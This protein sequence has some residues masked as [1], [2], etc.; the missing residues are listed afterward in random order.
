VKSWEVKFDFIMR[1][2]HW[3]NKL[4]E[5]CEEELRY[6]SG[7]LIHPDGLEIKPKTARTLKKTLKA[8]F[9][10]ESDPRWTPSFTNSIYGSGRTVDRDVRSRRFLEMLK[11]VDGVFAQRFCAFPHEEWT[12]EKYDLFNLKLIWELISDEFLD[13]QLTDKG[14]LLTTRFAE[15]KSARGEFKLYSS[16][17][18]LSEIGQTDLFNKKARWLRF[19][20]PLYKEYSRAT[21]PMNQTYLHGVLC[22]TRGAGKPPNLAKLQSKIKF[23]ETVTTPDNTGNTQVR[24]VTQAMWEEITL[25]PDHI[26]TGLATKA[27]VT[28]NTSATIEYTQLQHGTVQAIQDICKGRAYGIRAMDIDLETGSI[29]G[30]LKKDISEGT[31]VF[32]RCLEEVLRM[33]PEERSRAT[34][35][36]VDE[37]G[38]NRAVTKGVACLKVVLD[39]VN[40]ICAIPL[41]KGFA[42]SHSGMKKANHMWNVFKEYEVNPLNKLLFNPEKVEETEFSDHKIRDTEFKAVFAVSTDYETATDYLSH[43]IGKAIAYPWMLKCG[44]PRV[45][46]NLVCEVAFRPRTILYYGDPVVGELTGKEPNQRSVQSSRGVLMGDPLT[47]VVLHFTNIVS[48]RLSW[49]ILEE[50]FHNKVFKEGD[51]PFEHLRALLQTQGVTTN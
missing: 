44:I 2:T 31:Y 10:G 43:K 48:R 28:V 7:E 9:R 47:K 45:L 42:S 46:R 34:V 20:L 21:A 5:L 50:D 4:Q 35:V 24:M 33:S 23:I 25:L 39:F 37:P 51:N 17:D 30:Y 13:G 8:F 14:K 29:R 15:L 6:E 36:M 49:R 40:K 26:F 12:Y 18:R 27:R 22:Q 41:E 32:F 16:N 3:G 1:H 38:K 19:L 11:T